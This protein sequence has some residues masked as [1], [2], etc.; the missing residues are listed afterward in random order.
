MLLVVVEELIPELHLDSRNDFGTIGIIFGF[1][2]MMCLDN[3]F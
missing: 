2:I 1:L 3:I